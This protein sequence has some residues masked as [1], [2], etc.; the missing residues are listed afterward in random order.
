MKY[1]DLFLII[2]FININ[3]VSV[4]SIIIPLMKTVSGSRL[5]IIGVSV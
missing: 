2:E 1:E 4:L 3:I 5:S